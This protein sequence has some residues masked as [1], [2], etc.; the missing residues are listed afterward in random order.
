MIFRASETVMPGGVSVKGRKRFAARPVP[1]EHS[2]E[3]G[4]EVEVTLDALAGVSG[5]LLA[6]CDQDR[7]LVEVK[8]IE[9]GVLIKLSQQMI[10]SRFGD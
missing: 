8:V 6:L 1:R 2:P 10:R 4:Q 3:I 9:R 7:C 5:V